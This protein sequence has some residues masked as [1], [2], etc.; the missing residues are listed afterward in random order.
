MAL[1]VVDT[2][3]RGTVRG[4]GCAAA[5]MVVVGAGGAL[6]A[7]ADAVVTGAGGGRADRAAVRDVGADETAVA[8]TNESGGAS[9]MV[10]VV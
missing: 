3:A 4:M 5:F 2:A 6:G 10:D 9:G 8:G 1:K 7:S